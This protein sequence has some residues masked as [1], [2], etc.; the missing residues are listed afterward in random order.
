[1]DIYRGNYVL[2]SFPTDD[3]T[4][5]FKELLGAETITADVVLDR[6][7]SLRIGD[8]VIHEG[9]KYYLNNPADLE[10]DAS[11][12]YTITFVSETYLLYNKIVRH[13]GNTTFSYTGT[14]EELLLLIRD[15]MREIDPFWKIG[16]VVT[17]TEPITF[18]IDQQSCRT[19]LTQV[20][21]AFGLEY[22]VDDK[23]INLVNRIGVDTDV[24]LEYGRNKGLY[25]L[26]RAQ[27]D[28]TFGTVFYGYGANKNLPISYR[29]GLGRLT[30]DQSPVQAN[31]STYGYIENV[32]TFDDI[33]PNRT[34]TVETVNS[35]FEIVDST[36]DFDLNSLFVTEGGAKIVFKSGAL[37]GNELPITHYDHS[38]KTI[39]FG[40]VEED[41]G[42]VLPNDTF[43]P[44]VGDKYTMIGI[45]MPQSYIDAAEEALRLRTIEYAEKNSRPKY[46]YEADVDE[47]YIRQLSLRD[48]FIPGNSLLIK[49]TSLGIEERIRIQSVEYPLVNL[50][51]VTMVISDDVI[52]SRV[53]RIA[54]D[55]KKQARELSQTGRSATYAKA[56]SDE[57]RNYA[58]MDQFKRTYVGDRAVMTGV[59][60]AGNPD[61][62]EVAGI[63]GV[64][65][66]LAAIRFWAGASFD[67]RATAPFRV[68]QDGK[69]YATAMEILNGCKIGVFEIESGFIKSSD[70]DG[71]APTGILISN[72]GI[73]SRN[74]AASFIS[75]VTGLD[76]K[77]SFFGSTN[78]AD[79]LP[80]F[81]YAAVSA[82]VI[83]VRWNLLNEKHFNNLRYSLGK[84]GGFFNSIKNLGAS[85]IALRNSELTAGAEVIG[86]DDH[87]VVIYDSRTSATLPEDPDHGHEVI[88]KNACSVAINVDAQGSNEILTLSNTLVTTLALPSSNVFKAVYQGGDDGRWIEI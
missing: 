65:S 29:D 30:F 13:L 53:D 60:V 23:T 66:V 14:P 59:F 52:Y 35:N 27:T 40:T 72:D 70:Y 7:V 58:L 6:P 5:Y 46:A 67:N 41:S 82:G 86:K 62:G 8:Y 81:A 54:R 83:G 57:I 20:A 44:A 4:I 1:M 71:G 84:Y 36:I 37:A 12:R 26:R 73:A 87:L 55:T 56:A 77:G 64:D 17:I 25:A 85:S 38:T 79:D 19:L 45:E 32:V 3:A 47:K 48:K 42:Y 16:D 63:S 22:F 43:K 11:Y 50:E 28:E 76:I 80:V 39:R 9:K 75:D 15:N 34:G 51:A 69:A 21:E 10:R 74:A 88:L 49:D 18:S 24:V 33:F 2:T 61:D 68:Q 31:V 78:E